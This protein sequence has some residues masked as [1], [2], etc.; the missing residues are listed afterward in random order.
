MMRMADAISA[1]VQL[2]TH[3]VQKRNR[4]VRAARAAKALIFKPVTFPG[5][6]GAA[7]GTY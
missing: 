5:V 6:L 3:N 2:Q 1:S 7:L 4:E